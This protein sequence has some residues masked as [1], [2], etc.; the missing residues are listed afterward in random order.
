MKLSEAK[1]IVKRYYPFAV[2]TYN[3]RE[4]V[5]GGEVRITK[6]GKLLVW[7]EQNEEAAWIAAAKILKAARMEGER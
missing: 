4:G 6:N 2:G 7:G 1:R 3:H 5:E